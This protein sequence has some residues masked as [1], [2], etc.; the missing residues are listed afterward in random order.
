MEPD[1]DL[2]R[3]SKQLSKRFDKVT[4]KGLDPFGFL[5]VKNKGRTVEIS[6]S[7]KETENE[8]WLEFWEADEDESAPPV[9]ESTVNSVQEAVRA[10]TQWLTQGQ[11]FDAARSGK[12]A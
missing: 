9:T 2:Q 6:R 8:W 3:I 12:R 4:R 11:G 7:S 10:A 1:D 5:F